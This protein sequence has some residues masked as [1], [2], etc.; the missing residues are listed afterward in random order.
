LPA[1]PPRGHEGWAIQVGA[2]DSSSNAQAALGIAEL[3]AVQMLVN[4]HPMVMSVHAAGHVKYRA[5]V[6][7][8]QHEDAVN[9]CNRLSNGP[10]GCV[11]LPPEAQS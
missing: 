11:V 3:A 7:G 1:A 6:G 2:Y 5:R 9:A 4:G 10:T 8:L